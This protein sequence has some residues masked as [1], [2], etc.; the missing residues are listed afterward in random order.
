MVANVPGGGG[1]TGGAGAIV[2]VLVDVVDVVEV[3]AIAAAETS[4]SSA[5][6]VASVIFRI[7][8]SS[9]V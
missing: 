8:F 4:I 6:P 1:V 9:K 3:C 7:S 5:V 2:L